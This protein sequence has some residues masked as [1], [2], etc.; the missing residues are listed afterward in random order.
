MIYLIGGAPKCGKTTLAKILSKTFG[1]PWVS[2]DTL[3]NVVKPYMRADELSE[4]F[5]ATDQRC[6]NNDEK[7]S[8]F[9]AVEIIYAYKRQ[10][11]TIYPA[12]DMFAACEIADG[13]DF[14][15]EGYHIKPE[16]AGELN[17]KYPG[18]TKAIFLVKSDRDK[19][20]SD[21]KKSATPNDWIIARTGKPETYQKIAN[22]ICEYGDFFNKEA[23][24]YGFKVLNMDNDF[25]LCII[26]AIN[27]FT[28]K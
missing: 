14:I 27:Y 24:K 1:I 5:P 7:Y 23:S 21:I 16:L 10:A 6:E 19:F 2:T 18:K 26:E 12:I 20:V 28:K 13:N 3:Q 4:K 25:D 17:K 9:T 15:I 8:R 11:K 22:M